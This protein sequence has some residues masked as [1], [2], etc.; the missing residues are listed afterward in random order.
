MLNKSNASFRRK[1]LMGVSAAAMTAVT[2]AAGAQ[3]AADA[4]DEV[5]VTGSET[6]LERSLD[7]KQE[8]K[9]VVDAIS[10]EE[11]VSFLTLTSLNLCGSA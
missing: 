4:T 9:G 2:S 10:A 5:V 1:M 7:I 3:E 8:A 11:W 6:N